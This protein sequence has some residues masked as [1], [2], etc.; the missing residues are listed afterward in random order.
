M[1]LERITYHFAN[2]LGLCYRIDTHYSIFWTR[3]ALAMIYLDFASV[4]F[5]TSNTITP[6]FRFFIT[7]SSLIGWMSLST[8]TIDTWRR[9][10]RIRNGINFT[11]I[12]FESFRTETFETFY[13]S[14][15]FSKVS[16]KLQNMKHSLLSIDSNMTW[17][18]QYFD[19]DHHFDMDRLHM[20]HNHPKSQTPLDNICW[21][22]IYFSQDNKIHWVNVI[23]SSVTE[24]VQSIPLT[25]KLFWLY[26]TYARPVVI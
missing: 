3:I 25:Q 14:N 24:F 23:D 8:D 9:K 26:L 21:F 17:N 20:H 18:C 10:T 4:A 5:K 15:I 6:E 1:Y 16:L 19:N 2:A 12:A 22:P 13:C 7:W 11:S